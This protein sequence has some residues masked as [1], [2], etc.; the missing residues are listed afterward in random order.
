MLPSD[1]QVPAPNMLTPVE[2][3][4]EP[5][6]PLQNPLHDIYREHLAPKNPNAVNQAPPTP[7]A[8]Q[9]VAPFP[10][11]EQQVPSAPQ[12]MSAQNSDEDEAVWMHRAKAVVEQTQNDPYRRLQMIQQ[13]QAQ[14]QA[15]HFR[16]D[17]GG[18]SSS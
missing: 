17:T 9:P 13:L 2:P 18:V 8:T 4:I 11:A 16:K 12:P 3:S 5:T 6:A 14:Y 1:D 15:E 7:A 10:S